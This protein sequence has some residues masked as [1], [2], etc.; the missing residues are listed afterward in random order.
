M[1]P[2]TY[3]LNTSTIR[4]T[5]FPDK[6]RIAAAA[7]FT[8]I[9][10]WN[11]E[12]TALELAGESVA[13]IRKLIEDAGLRVPSMIALH[14]WTAP[15]G[16]EYRRALE[17]CKRRMDQAAALGC[18]TI[19]ASPPP[20]DIDLTLAADRFGD[21]VALG[22]EVG[23][24]PSME[25]LG[26]VSKVHTLDSAWRIVEHC[27]FPDLPIVADVFHLLRGGGSLD[28]LL[29]VPGDRISIFH[30]NDLPQ[31]PPYIAQTD[32]DR[33]MLGEGTADLPRVVKNLRTIGYRGP[34]SLELFNRALWESDPGEV[35]R[36]GLARMKA[37][38][39]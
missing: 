7:G 9:E 22:K 23:V 16:E 38:F 1:N 20:G 21:L 11:D 4:P 2:I 5:P 26:F 31:V 8:A 3:C 28:E 25:F 12:V 29:R 15:D 27:G 34:V 39:G 14:G 19:V 37:L 13:E 36:V 6:I 32:A 30:I 17:E 24:T 35:C 18:P 33:V 10:P